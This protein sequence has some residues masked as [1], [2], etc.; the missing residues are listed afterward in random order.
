MFLYNFATGAGGIEKSYTYG[1][2]RPLETL[3]CIHIVK[4]NHLLNGVNVSTTSLVEVAFAF[5]Y[6]LHSEQ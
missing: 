6:F 2:S 1:F 3:L 4:C 5:A